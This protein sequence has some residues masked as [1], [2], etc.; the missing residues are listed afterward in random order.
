MAVLAGTAALFPPPAAAASTDEILTAMEAVN[1]DVETYRASVEFSVG[2]HWPLPL[3]KTVHGATY[4]KRPSKMEVVF[5]DLPAFAQ[6]F[7]NVYVGLG[8]PE[9]WHRKFDI[10]TG[11]EA[12]HEFLILTPKNAKRLRRVDVHLDEASNLPSRIVWT[13]RDGR[14]EMVQTIARIDGEYVVA[15]QR[16]EIRLP[17][18]SAWIA[19]SVRDYSF[20]VPIDDAIFT[21]K[22]DPA[23]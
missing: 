14:I 17:G 8:T 1:P 5:A 18:V 15:A 11:L 7:R 20:N 4:F 21:K 6:Q 12:G 23:S 10:A 22:A 13:Y 16:A 3:R 9:D 2:L 19:T